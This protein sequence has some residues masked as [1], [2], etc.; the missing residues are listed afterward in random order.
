LEGVRK[1]RLFRL[2]CGKALK[3]GIFERWLPKKRIRHAECGMGLRPTIRMKVP[4][5]VM[6][7]GAKHLLFLIEDKQ[8]RA[9]L[10]RLR[11]QV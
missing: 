9:L 6:L 11:D 1:S 10:P 5:P 3:L 7:S 2:M 8:E 4:V